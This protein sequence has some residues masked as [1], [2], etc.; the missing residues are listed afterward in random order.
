MF[1]I[2][3]N[4]TPSQHFLSCLNVSR[5]PWPTQNG[6]LHKSSV[7]SIRTYIHR[8]RIPRLVD[9]EW[10]EFDF[11]NLDKAIDPILKRIDQESWNKI[12]TIEKRQ[13]ATFNEDAQRVDVSGEHEYRPPTEGKSIF[14]IS[15][16][17]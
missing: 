17:Y 8:K 15:A 10:E 9:G 4:S 12:A 5:L 11:E 1:F 2:K 3:P 13:K 16:T 7:G 6:Q 14:T